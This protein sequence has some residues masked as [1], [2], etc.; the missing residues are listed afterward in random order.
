[1]FTRRTSIVSSEDV[2]AL[3]TSGLVT[4]SIL[5]DVNITR[6]KT[7][8]AR[9]IASIMVSFFVVGIL[10]VLSQKEIVPKTFLQFAIG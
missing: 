8:A 10:K 1:M 4:T 3:N 5:E 6:S 2:L 9:I 7:S